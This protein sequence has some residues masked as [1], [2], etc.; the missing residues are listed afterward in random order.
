MQDQAF[1]FIPSLKIEKSYHLGRGFSVFTAEL[2]AIL[3]ALTYLLN[4]P[5]ELINVIFC[6]DSKSVLQSLASSVDSRNNI[7]NEVKQIIHC[8]QK[9]GNSIHFCWIPSHC[10]IM[11]NDYVDGCKKH[12]RLNSTDS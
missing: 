12:F 2:L 3:M 10:G 9:K 7:I 1:C 5:L 6:V 4:I 8:I 11:N